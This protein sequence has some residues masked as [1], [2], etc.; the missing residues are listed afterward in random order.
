MTPTFAYAQQVAHLARTI[1]EPQRK[2]LTLLYGWANEHYP[3]P[4]HLT[5]LE[6]RS[7]AALRR[8]GLTEGL[9]RLSDLGKHVYRE[10]SW[11]GRGP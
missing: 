6:G 8:R 2:L 11:V 3:A 1:S 10:L 4:R 7:Y 9:H 5:A